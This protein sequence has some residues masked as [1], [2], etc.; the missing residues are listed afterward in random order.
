MPTHHPQASSA[1][2]ASAKTARIASPLASTWAHVR[3]YVLRVRYAVRY[4]ITT[5]THRA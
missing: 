1:T 4:A 5:I 2:Q 3:C